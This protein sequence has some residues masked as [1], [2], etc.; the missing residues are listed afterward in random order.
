M[1]PFLKRLLD[2]ATAPYRS[3][4]RFAWHFARGKL[5]GD[6]A[7]AGLLE[8]GAFPAEANVLD[9][10]C[11]QGLLA[12]WLTSARALYE[13]GDWP[14]QWPTPP[15]LCSYRG[16]ELMSSDI[17]RARN[18]VGD[19]VEWV[20]GDIRTTEFGKANTVVI[21]DV[22]HYIKPE[23]QEQVLRRVHQALQP[24]GRLI[25]R[26]GDQAG[27]LPFLFSKLVDLAVFYIR[28]HRIAKLHTRTLAEWRELLT[29]LG[30]AV[31]SMPMHKGTPFAST[32]LL[33]KVGSGA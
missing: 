7:F 9:L 25:L 12:S 27:G 11:G 26:I 5:S 2:R 14:S 19:K 4:G 20:L 1:K 13:E 23:E 15:K 17:E 3:A 21:L 6:P 16:V 18:A 24:N 8:I 29:Q 22:L 33:A 32:L 28:G 10:G 31:E 30:F